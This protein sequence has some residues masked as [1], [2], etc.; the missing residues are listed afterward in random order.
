MAQFDLSVFRGH[1][2]PL[3][4]GDPVAQQEGRSETGLDLIALHRLDWV[5]NPLRGWEKDSLQLQYF[6]NFGLAVSQRK[7]GKS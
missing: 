1:Q 6:S 7:A 5:V 4:T 2:L 3:A